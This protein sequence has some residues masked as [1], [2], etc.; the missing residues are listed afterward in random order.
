MGAERVMVV[1]HYVAV[2]TATAIE[3]MRRLCGYYITLLLAC[4]IAVELPGAVVRG[5]VIA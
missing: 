1:H 4:S 2:V 5:V 3:P